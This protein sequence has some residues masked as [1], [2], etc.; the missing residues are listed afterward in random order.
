MAQT[1]AD[2]VNYAYEGKKKMWANL[3]TLLTVTGQTYA[4]RLGSGKTVDNTTIVEIMNA[5]CDSISWYWSAE[6]SVANDKLTQDWCVDNDNMGKF[7]LKTAWNDANEITILSSQG[8]QGTR[9]NV[10]YP[11][12]NNVMPIVYPALNNTGFDMTTVAYN[13]TYKSHYVQINNFKY[14][15]TAYSLNTAL[16]YWIYILERNL[17]Y[18]KTT[19]LSIAGNSGTWQRKL[20]YLYAQ[21]VYAYRMLRSMHGT[22]SGYTKAYTLPAFAS[23]TWDHLAAAMANLRIVISLGVCS[24]YNNNVTYQTFGVPGTTCT[25]YSPKTHDCGMQVS[26]NTSMISAVGMRA[27]CSGGSAVPYFYFDS[28]TNPVKVRIADGAGADGYTR[29]FQLYGLMNPNY[30]PYH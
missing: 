17:K 16:W 23:C 20:D 4:G 28:I 10:W 9:A 19:L 1:V 11:D 6:H 26:Y 3:G 22:T 5:F 12:N 25:A 29:Y 2:K 14:N 7:K 30:Y 15:N 18:S 24:I 13:S 21:K 27:L 8:N